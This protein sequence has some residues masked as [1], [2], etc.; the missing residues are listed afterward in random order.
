MLSSIARSPSSNEYL[1]ISSI[2]IIQEIT[3]NKI[4]IKNLPY[5]IRQIFCVYFE[6]SAGLLAIVGD[7]S[8]NRPGNVVA[9]T[10]QQGGIIAVDEAG[11][12]EDGG[13]IGTPQDAEVVALF[14]AAVIIAVVDGLQA[15]D[16]LVLD[17][18]G[19]RP[20][21]TGDVVAVGL[22][23]AAAARVDVDADEEVC[24]PAVGG[25]DDTGPARR[26][27]AQVLAL[28]EFHGAA[29]LLEIAAGKTAIGQREVAFAQAKLRIDAA[30]VGIAAQGLPGIDEYI[31][32]FLLCY[33]TMM[34]S[35][36]T[37]TR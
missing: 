14:D 34:P 2:F 36:V 25:I 15:G 8:C 18:G 32:S 9:V 7:A 21:L 17:A 26:L 31:H 30:G 27:A 6:F 23:A 22:R 24:G 16:E 19:E 28:Q 13:H 3:V 29:R 37:V 20:R 35:L 33:S 1:R 10:G 5:K 12:D 4:D 11:L